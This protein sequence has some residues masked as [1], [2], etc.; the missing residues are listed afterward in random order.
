MVPSV[1][2]LTASTICQTHDNTKIHIAIKLN[3]TYYYKT[4]E[5]TDRATT[6]S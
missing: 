3:Y 1:A 2:Y 6:H 4:S 5:W